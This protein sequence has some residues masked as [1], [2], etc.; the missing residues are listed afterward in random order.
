MNINDL[1]AFSLKR[2]GFSHIKVEVCPCWMMLDVKG[3]GQ[4]GAINHG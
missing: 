2:H 3:G 4:G 1:R